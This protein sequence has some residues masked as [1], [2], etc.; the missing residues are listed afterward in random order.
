MG[1]KVHKEP[2]YYF[3]SLRLLEAIVN[4]AS[5]KQT[6]NEIIDKYAK[7]AEE[8]E[9]LSS[10][11]QEAVELEEYVGENIVF[12][13]PGLELSGRETAEFLYTT[14]DYAN[15]CPATAFYFYDLLLTREPNSK[16]I[17][18]LAFALEDDYDEKDIDISPGAVNEA[19]LFRLVESSALDA[20]AKY[21]AL[22][23]YFKFDAYYAYNA[24]LIADVTGLIKDKQHIFDE[25]I[26]R[27][28]SYI[29]AE[30]DNCGLRLLK[31]TCGLEISE[32]ISYDIC[33]SL[34]CSNALTVYGS[35]LTRN[36]IISGLC[37]FDLDERI[38]N[39]KPY[40]DTLI[41]FIKAL[42]DNTKLSIIQT[43]MEEP[44]Y[45]VQLAKKLGLT[46]ATISH[47][48]AALNR[49][50][51]VII[52]KDAARVYYD[53]NKEKLRQYMDGVQTLLFE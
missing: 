10:F 48:M 34:Y 46:G 1:N 41:E 51:L 14:R 27:F 8:K 38:K 9:E 53:L 37:V 4:K 40:R 5:M 20:A 6:S 28:V 32:E 50:N 24:R 42:A 47:H 35:R 25:K 15:N 30:V 11:F 26:N 21:E 49:L 44:C 2:D 7:N 17:S 36:Q 39:A 18:V 31:E 23:L 3:D 22:K 16:L 13:I 33:I 45:G 19:E 12:E 43:L 52:K 29:S